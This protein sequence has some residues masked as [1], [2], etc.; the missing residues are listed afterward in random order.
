[1]SLEIVNIGPPPT[2]IV[3][4]ALAVPQPFSNPCANVPRRNLAG[5]WKWDAMGRVDVSVT[6]AVCSGRHE[7]DRG[8]DGDGAGDKAWDSKYAR[9]EQGG[10]RPIG[11]NARPSDAG[12]RIAKIAYGVVMAGNYSGVVS[13]GETQAINCSETRD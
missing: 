6:K 11:R 10:W 5:R 9:S 2:V 7:T 13:L 12:K 3:V 1:V 4:V 8:V